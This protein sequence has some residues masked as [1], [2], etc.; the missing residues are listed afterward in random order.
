MAKS[1]GTLTID[2]VAKTAGFTAGL[3]KAERDSAK[4]KKKVSSNI[5]SAAAIST[6]AIAA[7]ATAAATGLAVI[8][9][10]QRELIDTQLITAQSLNT[11]YASLANLERAGDLPCPD[12]RRARDG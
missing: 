10:R 8:I 6:K 11:T 7:T 9:D 5:S 1:L 12:N 4:W 2:I 3:D